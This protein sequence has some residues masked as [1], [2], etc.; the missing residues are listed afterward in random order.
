MQLAGAQKPA[1]KWIPLPPSGTVFVMAWLNCAVATWKATIVKR[2]ETVQR[3]GRGIL[4]KHPP[5]A[6]R[7]TSLLFRRGGLTLSRRLPSLS[8]TRRGDEERVGGSGAARCGARRIYR[9]LGAHDHS[10]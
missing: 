2:V 5:L 8:E 1:R 10:G 3:V 4:R 6:I 7:A 9:P